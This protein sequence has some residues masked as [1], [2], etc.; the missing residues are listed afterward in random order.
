MTILSNLQVMLET[1]ADALGPELCDQMTFVGGC[2]TGLLLTDEFTKEGVRHTDDVDLI[3]QTAGL[4]GFHELQRTLRGKGFTTPGLSETTPICAMLLGDLRVDFMPDDESVLGFSNRWYP[5][6]T[7][8]ATYY[9]LRPG[10]R[11]KLVTP[12]YFLATKLEAYQGRGNGDALGS[13]DIEDVLT[14]VDGNRVLL[15]AV[16]QAEVEVK[17]Y[18]AD[19]LRRLL[20]DSNFEHAVSSQSRGDQGREDLLFERLEAL[21]ACGEHSE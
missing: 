5:A 7:Q 17:T 6:A 3:V 13:R 4:V 1:V 10:T 8:T 15:D 2:T 18:I 19:S 14:L 12:L 21:A 9:E 11:I 20:A 16:Q